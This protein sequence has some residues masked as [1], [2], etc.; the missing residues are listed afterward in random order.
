MRVK[1][2]A[3]ERGSLK[4][5][6]RLV[7]S[8][9]DVLSDAIIATGVV[10]STEQLSWKSPLA[11]DDFAEYRD[12][13][14]L[15]V[16]GHGELRPKLSEFWPTRG[17][18]WDALAVGSNG[19]VV[20]VEAKAHVNELASSCQASERSLKTINQAFTATKQSLG[21]AP[22]SDWLNGYYQYA[23]RLAHLHF[24]RSHGVPTAL[25]FLYIVDDTDMRGPKTAADWKNALEAPYRHLG[26]R[27][28]LPLPG[29]ASVFIGVDRLPS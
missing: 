19:T 15:D 25:V 24:L 23:N 28:G 2:K 20:L 4:W 17:P 7:G 10:P 27:E 26:L 11:G 14:F 12:G 13:E 18:Q 3:G 1:Q 6:Q 21:V 29:V 16:V 22:D 9:E 8:H 5:M